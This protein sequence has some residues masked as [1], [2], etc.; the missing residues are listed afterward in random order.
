MQ[1]LYPVDPSGYLPSGEVTFPVATRHAPGS[2][3]DHG[4]PEK[5]HMQTFLDQ[6]CC[7][8]AFK[9]VLPVAEI[10][11]RSPAGVQPPRMC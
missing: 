1:C 3:I 4:G 6:A 9:M 7:D 8:V 10:L 11:L 2:K 5:T